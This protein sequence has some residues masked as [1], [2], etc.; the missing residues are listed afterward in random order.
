MIG[1]LIEREDESAHEMSLKE[2][3]TLSYFLHYEKGVPR[4]K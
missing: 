4:A 1:D 3:S 2:G